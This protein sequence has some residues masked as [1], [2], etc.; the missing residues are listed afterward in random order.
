MLVNSI[1]KSPY[2]VIISGD[3]N[4]T[5][6]SYVYKQ[7]SNDFN[8]AFKQKGNGFGITFNYNYVP[9]RIDFILTQKLFKIN[10][11]QTFKLNLS[12]HEPIYSEISY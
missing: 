10:K 7:L 4:N 12:D 5:A 8:D 11:F 6:F 1:T 3:L 2:K 9:L